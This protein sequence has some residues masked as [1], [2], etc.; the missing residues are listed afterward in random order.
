M[1]RFLYPIRSLTL[2]LVLAALALAASACGGGDSEATVAGEEQA[3]AARVALV[4]TELPVQ[5]DVADVAILSADLEPTRRAVLAAEVAGVVE[6]LPV[7]LGQRVGAGQTVA[8]VDTRSL[9]QAVA[10]AQALNR[11]AQAQYGRAEVLFEKRSI[12]K[13]Q[14]LDALTNRDVA[15][16]RL[17]SAQL[18]LSKSRVTAPWAGRIS[19]KRAEVGD[20]VNPGMAI[21]ELVQVDTLKVVAMAPAGDVPYL[22]V[23]RPVTIKVDA[24]PG[25]EFTGKVIRLGA[26]LDPQ[27]RTLD[28]EAEIANTDG[29]LKPG[30]LARMEVPRRTLEGAVLVPLEAVVDLGEER[31][32]FVTEGGVAR[33]RIVELG[34]VI[35]ERVVIL[36]GLAAGEPVIVEGERRVADGQPVEEAS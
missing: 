29:R 19:A 18:N 12:T 8:A 26:V 23:G 1:Q 9:E 5:Q 4:R 25:E 33:R 22:E 32:L 14:M 20:Y 24:L 13:A 31:A 16:S 27:S 17:A 34:P 3:P 15:E 6:R 7:E 2:L 35:G 11:Q 36:S 28:V 10:E 30:M 21:V